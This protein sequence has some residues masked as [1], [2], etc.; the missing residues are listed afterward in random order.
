MQTLAGVLD[1]NVGEYALGN[2]ITNYSL[3]GRQSGL[4]DNRRVAGF[5]PRQP[6][7]R[8]P[9]A[10][11]LTLTAPDELAVALHGWHLQQWMDVCVWTGQ[12]KA[13]NC[14]VL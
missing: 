8:C 2:K 4:S 6:V 9:W 3:L 10:R 12:C 1:T 14:K 5:I 13:N 11:L 7:S